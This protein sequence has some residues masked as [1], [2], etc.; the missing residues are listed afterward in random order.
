MK[1][2]KWGI[3]PAHSEIGFKVKHLMIDNVRGTFHEFEASIYTTGADFVTAEIDFWLNPESMTLVMQKEMSTSKVPTFLTWPP[4][5]KSALWVTP[6]RKW[7]KME[8]ITSM[9][10]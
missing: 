3:D 8:V 5:R 10:I 4:S 1:K 6:W 2:I 9:A 7:T